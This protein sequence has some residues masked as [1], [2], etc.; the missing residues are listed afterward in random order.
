MALPK[1]WINVT[2]PG[3]LFCRSTPRLT[4]WFST[5]TE[6]HEAFQDTV[7]HSLWLTALVAAPL[8]LGGT[9]C[10]EPI[11]S[12]LFGP[13][14]APAVPA[15][16]I[17]AWAM[18]LIILRDTYR[19]AFNAVRRPRLDL[20][21]AGISVGLNVVL[22][23]LLIPRYGM[24]GAAVATLVSETLWLTMAAYYFSRDVMPVRLL[25]LLWQ[26]GVAALAM[27]AVFMLTQPL[28]WAVR[29]LLSVLVYC[30]VFLLLETTAIGP[31][32]SRRKVY[33]P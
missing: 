24:R 14:Y 28:F 15:L 10:A 11:I 19:Q 27:G 6:G 8:G 7:V 9:L 22:N 31:F 32:I 1:R 30:G 5:Y 29:A 33:V 4:A 18:A 25:P 20:R 21:C 3:W 12:L 13:A 2:D 16:Q 26:P 17:L 23:V